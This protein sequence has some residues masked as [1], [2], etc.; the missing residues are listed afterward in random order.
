M[1]HIKM[2]RLKQTRIAEWALPKDKFDWGLYNKSQANE[3]LLFLR[4]LHE[5]CN[6]V[7]TPPEIRRGRKSSTESHK[8]YSMCLKIYT[9]MGGRRFPSEMEIAKRFGYLNSVTH[10]NTV[11]NYFD[12]KTITSK[13][14]Y[15]IELSALPLAQLEANETYAIDSTGISL[16]QYEER[17]SHAKRSYSRHR[18]YKKLHCICACKTNI[19]VSCLVTKGTANDSPHYRELLN[20]AARNFKIEDITADRAYLS[21]DNLNLAEELGINPFIPFKINNQN[22]GKGCPS[23]SKLY[24]FF[25]K[26]PEEFAKRYHKRSNVESVMFMIKNKFGGFCRFKK[27]VSQ[28]NE[29]LCMMLCHNLTILIQE[30]FLS[31]IEV[32]FLDMAREHVAQDDDE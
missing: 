12:S 4:L 10:F 8:I 13:L 7:E 28:I 15:L 14:K 9:N 24:N 17:W 5:L 20:D 26:H 23:W 22:F 16:K 1:V 31:G 32:D 6:M 27:D 11:L 30:I 2:T 21:K 29:I 25:H 3:K 19:I 18:K